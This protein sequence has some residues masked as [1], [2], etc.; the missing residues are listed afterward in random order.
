[1]NRRR[2]SQQGAVRLLA[3]IAVRGFDV[4]L[5]SGLASGAIDVNYSCRCSCAS[6]DDSWTAGQH[7][8]LVSWCVARVLGPSLGP[9]VGRLTV[10]VGDVSLLD[11]GIDAAPGNKSCVQGSA[12]ADAVGLTGRRVDD[13]G[14]RSA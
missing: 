4:V 9:F 8:Q 6:L 11:D 12:G 2:R 3:E 10:G 13:F 14:V 7:G 1:V 5:G